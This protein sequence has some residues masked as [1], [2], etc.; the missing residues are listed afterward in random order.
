MVGDV[1][2][3]CPRLLEKETKMLST[4]LGDVCIDDVNRSIDIIGC[5]G[6]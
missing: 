3:I 6:V 2:I 4:R 5:S 1:V